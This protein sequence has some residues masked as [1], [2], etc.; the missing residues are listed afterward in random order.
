MSAALIRFAPEVAVHNYEV[1]KE[2][3]EEE[4][5]VFRPELQL[6]YLVDFERAHRDELSQE[7]RAELREEITDLQIAIHYRGGGSGS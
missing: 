2:F 4:E 1:A 6:Q 7:A 3:L 5:L